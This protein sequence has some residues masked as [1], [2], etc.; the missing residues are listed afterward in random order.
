M[1][2]K[3]LIAAK[4]SSE[5]VYNKNLRA[6][7][8]SNLLELKLVQLKSIFNPK[9]IVV[10]SESYDILNIANKHDVCYI[11][12]DPYYSKST[13]SMSDVYKHMAE[14]IDSE[15]IAYINITNPL[16][17][18]ESYY[19]AVNVFENIY[20]N[21]YD[22]L[23]SCHDIKEFL[24]QDNK[25]LNY[26]PL[27]QCRSQDL[28]DI[29]A[30][31]FAMSIIPRKLMIKKKNIIGDKPYFYKLSDVESMDIDTPLDFYIAEKLWRELRY[32]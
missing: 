26:N 25:P 7:C 22:S 4:G 18:T 21:G 3:V 30:L 6:F 1:N 5:R 31:N 27:E 16:V 11:K 23:T 14:N 32:G 19:N 15:F 28:P 2:L 9:D 13:T 24:W 17:K 12:R 10:N 8:N 29:V 20:N